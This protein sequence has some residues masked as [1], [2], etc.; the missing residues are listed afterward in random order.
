MTSANSD[1]QKLMDDAKTTVTMTTFDIGLLGKFPINLGFF[2]LFP[3]IGIQYRMGIDVIATDGENEAK[4]S[5]IDGNDPLGDLSRLWLKAGVGID[6]PL[7]SNMYLRGMYLYGIGLLNKNE[8]DAQD[9]A[10]QG[11]KMY[12]QINHGFDLS[13]SLGLRF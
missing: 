6:I 1:V 10:N 2:T 5:D 7:G 11:T 4:Y 8:Q 3:A 9:T 13:V 12:D